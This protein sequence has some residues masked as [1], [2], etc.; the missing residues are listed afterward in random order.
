M[1]KDVSEFAEKMRSFEVCV[2]PL[3]PILEEP[4]HDGILELIQ[5]WPTSMSLEIYLCFKGLKYV[6]IA[7]SYSVR[8][9]TDSLCSVYR[10]G[11]W[12]DRDAEFP[13][14]PGY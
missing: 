4:N 8:T 3:D 11:L 14:F 1:C 6:G 12:A 2:V 9:D 10:K 5:W 13:F 7:S